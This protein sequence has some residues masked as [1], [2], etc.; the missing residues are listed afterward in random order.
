MKSL[1]ARGFRVDVVSVPFHAHPPSELVRQALAWRLLELRETHGRV[2]RP[3]DPHQVP[4]LPRA[5]TP[6]GRLAL[7]PAPRGLRPLRHASTAPLGAGPEDARRRARRSGPW[8]TRRSASAGAL[9]TISQNVADRLA[10]YNGL[11]AHAALPAPAAARPLPLRRLL[12]LPARAGRLDRTKRLELRCARSRS[13]RAEAR[14]KITGEG[15]LRRDL[16]QL[17]AQ[18]GVAGARGVP[19]LRPGARSSW[20]STRAAAASS[21]RPSTRTTAT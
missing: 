11:R 4:E 18:L 2:G 12:R 3:R 9:F 20:R 7:P 6:Q 16:E 5:G 8:T 19:G 17:A 15:P 13:R 10:R 1:A 14:L 21:T